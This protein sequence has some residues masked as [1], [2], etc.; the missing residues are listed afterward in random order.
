MKK[1]FR[2]VIIIKGYKLI[3]EWFD[4]TNVILGTMC[5]NAIKSYIHS[6]EWFIEYRNVIE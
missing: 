2:Y 5:I 3:T 4:A 1:Y 6:D